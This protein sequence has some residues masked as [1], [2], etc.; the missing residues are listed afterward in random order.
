M[1]CGGDGCV[2]ERIGMQASGPYGYQDILREI[3]QGQTSTLLIILITLIM[4]NKHICREH[5]PPVAFADSQAYSISRSASIFIRGVDV[6]QS[7]HVDCL[8][9]VVKISGFLMD[10]LAVN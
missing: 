1:P 3:R 2:S 5:L 9:R 10:K 7:L 6:S 4:K 8:L